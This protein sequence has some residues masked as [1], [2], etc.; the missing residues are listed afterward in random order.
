[1]KRTKE[2]ENT[3]E[4]KND[5]KKQYEQW[6][7]DLRT[8]PRKDQTFFI[9]ETLKDKEMLPVFGRF[10]FPR[11]I[12]GKEPVPECHIDLANEI[13]KRKNGAI[14]FPRGFAKTTW[15]KIDTIHDIVYALEPV[16]LYI[17][18]TIGEASFHFESIKSEFENNDLL[19]GVYGDLVPPNDQKA[20]KWTNKHFE[21]TNGINVVARGAGKG[22]GVNIKNQRPTKIICDD[23]ENDESVRSADQRKKLH[24]WLYNVIF[25]S[26][27]ARA[28]FIKMVGTVISPHCE[29]LK[30]YKKHGGIFRKAEE[31]GES[32]WP[33]LFPMEK[34]M[35]I[36]NDIGSRAYS[37]EYLNNPV[38]EETA[39]IKPHWVYD[40]LYSKPLE[41]NARYRKVIMFDPQAGEKES[42]DYYGLC[43]LGFYQKERHKY[44]LEV[45]K[46]RASQLDQA[47][48][49]VRT[50]Q[51]HKKFCNIVGIEKV[52]NQVAVYQLILQWK[53]GQIE[54]PD[55]D[56]ED[57]NIPLIFVEPR[58]KDGGLLKDKKAR[59]QLHEAEFERG[60]IH[61]HESMTGLIEDIIAFPELEHD[62][63]IDAV[64]YALDYAHKNI[65]FAKSTKLNN[66]KK[67]KNRN[68]FGNIKKERF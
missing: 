23:I 14:I 57:R 61:I 37:Q 20:K 45:Q 35:E 16:V 51:R 15:E 55:V 36:K 30:F 65:S 6:C 43:V 29:I 12:G 64:I 49:L 62:D 9:K 50:Y 33:F 41:A 28:G 1:M 44:I 53:A 27:D 66:N 60:E 56:D 21:T 2:S 38:N 39:L 26:R 34:L 63:H 3:Y 48:L 54:L 32:I 8:L 7:E 25:P 10:F 40:N 31:N 52:L 19:I 13:S 47:A 18:S 11:I 68:S 5:S 42:A 22:R 46:G 59:M 58:G 4:K 24:E 67:R 17:G